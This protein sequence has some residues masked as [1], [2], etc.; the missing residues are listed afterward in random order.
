MQ[1]GRR[2]IVGLGTLV[3]VGLGIYGSRHPVPATGVLVRAGYELGLPIFAI[4]FIVLSALIGR[5]R[6][7]TE[8]AQRRLLHVQTWRLK[9]LVPS[10]S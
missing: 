1:H 9:Q 7:R 10:V 8:D 3:L 5:R 4:G 6:G 2:W